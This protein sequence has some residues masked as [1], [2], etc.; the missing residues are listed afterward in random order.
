[1]E[2]GGI[3]ADD[4]RPHRSQFGDRFICE[5]E[6]EGMIE[7]LRAAA[8]NERGESGFNKVKEA[9]SCKRLQKKRRIGMMKR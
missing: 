4:R 5:A 6:N 2:N 9:V 8:A 1:M 3:D 7:M